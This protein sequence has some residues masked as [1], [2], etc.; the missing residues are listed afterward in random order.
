VPAAS[1]TSPALNSTTTSEKWNSGSP[2]LFSV[3]KA[4]AVW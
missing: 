4:A 2:R 3:W 1:A